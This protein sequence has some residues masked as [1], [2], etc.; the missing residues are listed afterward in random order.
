MCS[1][2][3]DAKRV[4]LR[5][6]HSSSAVLVLKSRA[7]VARRGDSLLTVV[8]VLEA[9]KLIRFPVGR[10]AAADKLHRSQQMS[11]DDSMRIPWVRCRE[12]A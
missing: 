2:K 12:D 10:K 3:D 8:A 1:V 5:V 4:C 11:K 9:F 7:R 6:G